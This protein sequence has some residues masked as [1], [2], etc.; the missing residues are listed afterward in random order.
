MPAA[1]RAVISPRAELAL[2][3]MAPT[4]TTPWERWMPPTR[5]ATIDDGGRVPPP[6][7]AASAL[8]ATSGS[9][10]PDSVSTMRPA[11]P[12][13]EQP[14]VSQLRRAVRSGLNLARGDASAAGVRHESG[15]R[16]PG[17]VSSAGSLS[18]QQP[19]TLA[20]ARTRVNAL[21]RTDACK[22]QL[23]GG[24]RHPRRRLPAPTWMRPR[25]RTQPRGAHL[26]RRICHTAARLRCWASSGRACDAKRWLAPGRQCHAR[27]FCRWP[28]ARRHT[29]PCHLRYIHGLQSRSR[30]RCSEPAQQARRGGCG[31]FHRRE[32]GQ[33]CIRASQ[34]SVCGAACR[35][36]CHRRGGGPR[37][38]GR[39]SVGYVSDPA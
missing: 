33:P 37:A 7:A 5:P 14:R 1:A 8:L 19:P 6:A 31:R 21:H 11:L 9:R 36:P 3:S 30:D 12:V 26:A 17:T 34:D 38:S 15:S 35:R 4:T 2:P 25:H 27:V 13:T 24:R 16:P 28:S 39:A 22:P 10:P 20:G 32:P 23:R 18:H 29:A